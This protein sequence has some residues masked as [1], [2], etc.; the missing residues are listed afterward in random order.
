MSCA[1]HTSPVVFRAHGNKKINKWTWGEPRQGSS[2]GQL[3]V[4]RPRLS[5]CGYRSLRNWRIWTKMRYLGYYSPSLD[6]LLVSCFPSH[7]S[8]WC[9]FHLLNLGLN[10]LKYYCRHNNLAQIFAFDSPVAG[11]NWKT[12]TCHSIVR[13]WYLVVCLIPSTKM[14]TL[15]N[16][17]GI[18]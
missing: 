2:C 1:I 9:G 7:P 17:I 8:I 5:V 10:C 12:S 3:L 4:L 15:R 11:Y 18:P 6:G 13:G 16:S 14:H